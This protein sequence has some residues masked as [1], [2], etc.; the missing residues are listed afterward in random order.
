MRLGPVWIGKL[1]P[2][3]SE[4]LQD[5]LDQWRASGVVIGVEIL[6]CPD[7]P[8]SMT[9]DGVFFSLDSPPHL[10]VKGCVRKP[11]CGCCTI[12]VLDDQDGANAAPA[13]RIGLIE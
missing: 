10:P 4:Q 13:R 5:D 12:A 2:G 1:S 6:G 8:A 7:C 9:M 3:A 11:C